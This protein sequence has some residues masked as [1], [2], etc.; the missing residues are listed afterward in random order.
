M[1]KTLLFGAFAAVALS[2]AAKADVYWINMASPDPEYNMAGIV[3][4]VSPNGEYAVVFDDEMHDGYL[5]RKSD[6]TKLEYLNWP[7]PNNPL[8]NVWLEV[9]GVND[10]G[11]VVGGYKPEGNK[12]YPFYKELDGE[13]VNLPIPSWAQNSNYAIGISENS[14]IIGGYVKGA[15]TDKA[16]PTEKYS[17]YWP[18]VW[19][20]GADGEYSYKYHAASNPD[21]SELASHQ[22]FFVNCMYTDGTADG[23]WLGGQLYWGVGSH[24][25]ALFNR[26]HVITGHEFSIVEVPFYYKGNIY[27]IYRYE[28]LDGKRDLVVSDSDYSAS[29]FICCDYDGNFFG[30]HYHVGNFSNLDDNTVE[31]TYHVSTGD[32]YTWGSYNVNTH[33]WTEADGNRSVSF[34]LSKDVFFV[35]H[36]LYTEGIGS[37]PIN[38]AD[39]YG[40]DT[41]G[42]NW[43]GVSSASKDGS[44]LGMNFT[45]IDGTGKETVHP[46]IAVLEAGVSGLQNIVADTESKHVILV[47]GDT[48]EVNGA[49]QVAVYDLNGVQV[50]NS[51]VTNVNAGIYIVVADGKS[52]K[53]LV[54]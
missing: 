47:Y 10:D 33:E 42:T 9:Y 6:P 51:D 8:S 44:V 46:F 50:G 40:I 49:E 3:T 48:I 12:Y 2:A 4:C 39:E 41:N 15:N 13:V 38:Y 21:D 1:K 34:A 16:D 20:K 11:T 23:T 26:G 22:G 28:C 37:T 14:N 25:S 31:K 52:Y 7:M 53:I 43:G 5:W 54:K 18:M 24:V 17:A 19:E 45:T 36:N 35:G 29:Q 27:G 30:T 32:T